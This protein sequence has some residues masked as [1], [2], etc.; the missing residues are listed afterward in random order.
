MVKTKIPIEKVEV[1]AEV[2]LEKQLE[3][4]KLGRLDIVA[5][6]NYEQFEEGPFHEIARIKRDYQNKILT[7]KMEVH[8]IQIPKFTREDR[9]I[10]TKL[11][12]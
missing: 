5:I 6:L 4:N 1:Q 12:Q 11:E 2:T 3:G 7:D 10:K 9:K 8:F